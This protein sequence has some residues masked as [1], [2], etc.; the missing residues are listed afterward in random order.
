MEGLVL[1]DAHKG[2]ASAPSLF[3]VED[4]G[5]MI[6]R[7]S[8][9]WERLVDAVRDTLERWSD[10]VDE[11]LSPPPEPVPVPVPVRDGRRARR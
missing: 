1:S 8:R 2:V 5:F 6:A 3:Y 4:G 10:A 9:L 7:T 11:W